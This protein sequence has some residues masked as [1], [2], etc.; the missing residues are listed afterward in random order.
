MN[1]PYNFNFHGRRPTVYTAFAAASMFAATTCIW[2]SSKIKQDPTVLSEKRW[3]DEHSVK[4]LDVKRYETMNFGETLIDKIPKFDY[5]GE[6]SP[7]K[8]H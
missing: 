7:F 4:G 3:Y 8:T 1:H 5:R 2:L 6:E